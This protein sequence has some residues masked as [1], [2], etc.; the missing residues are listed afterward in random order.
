MHGTITGENIFC[1]RD[2][3]LKNINSA[4]LCTLC[5]SELLLR[6]VLQKTVLKKKGKRGGKF[7]IFPQVIHMTSLATKKTKAHFKV[8][9]AP[10][11]QKM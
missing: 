2:N 11:H 5:L 6:W 8:S 1:E 7:H 9:C 10:T 3:L 4:D